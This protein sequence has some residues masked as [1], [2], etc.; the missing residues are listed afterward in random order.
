MNEMF[1]VVFVCFSAKFLFFF[2]CLFRCNVFHACLAFYCVAARCLRHK[3]APLFSH[4]VT[5]QLV[6]NCHRT[7]S[8]NLS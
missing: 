5:C 6:L 4:D 1:S 2:I 7:L 8:K 3:S